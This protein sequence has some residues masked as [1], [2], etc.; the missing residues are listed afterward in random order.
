M[1]YEKVYNDRLGIKRFLECHE[2]A[3]KSII[4]VNDNKAGLK[5]YSTLEHQEGKKYLGRKSLELQTR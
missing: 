2:S 3:P 4:I 1:V 5:M